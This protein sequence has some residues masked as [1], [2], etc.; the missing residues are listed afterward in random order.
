MIKLFR[1]KANR[2]NLNRNLYNYS[3]LTSEIEENE[4]SGTYL[5]IKK[6]LIQITRNPTAIYVKL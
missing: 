4:N 5:K 1:K 6:T 2:Q 3:D